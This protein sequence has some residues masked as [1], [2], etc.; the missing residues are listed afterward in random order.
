M[1][2]PDEINNAIGEKTKVNTAPGPD[3]IRA[4]V[5]RIP[6][7]FIELIAICFTSCL[8]RG[9]FPKNWKTSR[10]VLIPKGGVSVDGDIPKARPICLLSELGKLFERVI[11]GRMKSFMSTDQVADLAPSQFGF[12]RAHST[13]DAL[14]FVKDLIKESFWKKEI[15]IAVGIDVKN[16]FNSLPWRTIRRALSWRK[17]FPL[18]ICRIIDAYLSDRWII[19]GNNDGQICRRQVTAGVP[20]GSV[21]GPLLWNLSYDCVLRTQTFPGCTL[22]CY[23][24][25]TLLYATDQTLND[26]KGL[27]K[28][29]LRRTI[30]YIENLGLEISESKTEVVIFHP[31][32]IVN[33]PNIRVGKTLVQA[34]SQ[35]KYLGIILD[36]RLTFV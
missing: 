6:P 18:Y 24:D 9:I 3:E 32:G 19:F 29:Q 31:R 13:C 8:R 1:V 5:L 17:H 23:A 36:T 25:D 34:A 27:I 35:M 7:E 33:Y 21:L 22:I 4:A 15:A 30:P 28:R 26:V 16:A 2:T 20:Q 10:L 12:R 11:A 14:L